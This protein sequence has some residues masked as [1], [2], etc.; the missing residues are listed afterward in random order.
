[1]LGAPPTPT[2]YSTA[3]AAGV[4]S[5]HQIPHASTPYPR[6]GPSSSSPRALLKPMVET[7]ISH[8]SPLTFKGA[9]PTWPWP[10]GRGERWATSI[11]GG[12]GW[13]PPPSPVPS[14]SGGTPPK[15][16]VGQTAE[17]GRKRHSNF[18]PSQ[19]TH[20]PCPAPGTRAAPTH[21]FNVY[22]ARGGVAVLVG[23]RV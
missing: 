1:V 19:P 18:T 22:R 6:L 5:P 12:L 8:V 2:P 9:L 23:F 16:G 15:S 11:F 20:R 3:S 4:L 14:P 13:P 21:D 10:P 17:N 7:Y